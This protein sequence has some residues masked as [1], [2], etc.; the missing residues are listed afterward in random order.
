M[1][2]IITRSQLRLGRDSKTVAVSGCEIGVYLDAKC[3]V[4]YQRKDVAN[5][6]MTCVWIRFLK[7]TAA[8]LKT[9]QLTGKYVQE[10]DAFKFDLDD[11][12]PSLL[13]SLGINASA[14]STWYDAPL[15]DVKETKPV[16]TTPVKA[17]T[18]TATPTVTTPSTVEQLRL[19][20]A[21]AE[22]LEAE[23]QAEAQRLEAEAEAQRKGKF[24]LTTGLEAMTDGALA[25]LLY[26]LTMEIARRAVK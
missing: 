22:R 15:P 24:T 19:A 2:S 21:E 18:P 20:L 17:S 9:L 7:P 23:A 1:Q 6:A 12:I 26:N 16:K 14:P 8:Q 25:S 5:A 11:R 10:R 3:S 13:Q 4:S